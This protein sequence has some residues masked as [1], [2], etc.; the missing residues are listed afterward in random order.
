MIFKL[1][2]TNN[3]DLSHCVA[4]SIPFPAH[5]GGLHVIIFGIHHD[6]FIAKLNVDKK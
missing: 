6:A 3:K 5:N 2:T 4:D 1:L